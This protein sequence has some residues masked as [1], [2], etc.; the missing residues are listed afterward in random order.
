MKYF[1]KTPNLKSFEKQKYRSDGICFGI[2]KKSKKLSKAVII[3]EKKMYSYFLK[4][5]KE[6][7]IA[8]KDH[9]YDHKDFNASVKNIN[10][11]VFKI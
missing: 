9:I 6:S 2:E 4:N 7:T 5:D 8:L 10:E 11:K 3:T 1:I